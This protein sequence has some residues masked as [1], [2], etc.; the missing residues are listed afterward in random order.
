MPTAKLFAI[1][2]LLNVLWAPTNF[3]VKVLQGT[4]SPSTIVCIRW[5]LF[6]ALLWTVLAIPQT[7]RLLKPILPRK[8]DRVKAVLIGFFCVALSYNLYSLAVAK[9]STIEANILSSTYPVVMGLFAFL[10]LNERVGPQRWAAI[11]VG[12]AGAYIVSVGFAVPSLSQKHTLG[13]LLF[14]CGLI[15]ECGALTMAT[16]IVLRS[17]GL[18]TLAF[19]SLGA[20]LGSVAYPLVLPGVPA[21][22]MESLPHAAFLHMFYLV[23][24][25]GVFA[26]GVWYVL[27]E[28]APVSLMMLSTLIQPPIAAALGYLY[29]NETVTRNTVIGSAAIVAALII[30]ATEKGPLRRTARKSASEAR[31]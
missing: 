9:T 25:G 14:L 19:E 23:A 8:A 16:R 24:I 27:V 6:S 30:S 15:L 2:A 21:L 4:M 18:G 1:L 5:I 12:L 31:A 17:S 26:F 29:L 7:R 20:A 22:G 3:M 11:A 13:N 28:N 10:F